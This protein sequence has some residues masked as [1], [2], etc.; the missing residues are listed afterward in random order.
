M[1]KET[2][3]IAVQART[4]FGDNASRRLRKAGM[5][6]AIVYSKGIEP[7]AVQVSAD[8][9]KVVSAQKPEYI[10]LIEGD[11]E[12]P[13]LIREVQYNYLKNYVVHIDFQQVDMVPETDE[14]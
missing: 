7:R 6:P 11:K 14:A 12:T 10:M 13:A 9:W 5:I 2:Y 4:G 8:E 3:K 1:S